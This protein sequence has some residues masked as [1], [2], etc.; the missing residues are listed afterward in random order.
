MFRELSAAALAIGLAAPVIVGCGGSDKPVKTVSKKEKQKDVR[1]LLSEARDEAKAGEVD[2]ADALYEEAY[3]VR[4]DFEILEERV[5]FLLANG[6][7]GRAQ[8]VARA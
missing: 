4:A 8:A 3:T 7:P 5:D 1:A 6:K 2:A